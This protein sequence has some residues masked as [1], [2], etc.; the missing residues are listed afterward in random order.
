[1]LLMLQ[2]YRGMARFGVMETRLFIFFLAKTR[3]TSIASRHSPYLFREP[4]VDPEP[5][6]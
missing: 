2:P 5:V 4:V 6:P 3:A 1:M